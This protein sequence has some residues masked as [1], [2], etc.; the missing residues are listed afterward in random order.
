TIYDYNDRYRGI[1]GERRVLFMNKEDIASRGLKAKDLI[2]ITSHYEGQQRTV[3]KFIVVPYEIP[4]GNVSAYF[5]EANPLVPIS[6]VA[7][8]SNTPTSKYVVV[9][10]AP[11]KTEKASQAQK[12][13]PQAVPA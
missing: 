11:A 3:E 7:K 10:V 1:H 4:K 13:R 2:D 6:S 9:T 12:Q 5:P 8:V